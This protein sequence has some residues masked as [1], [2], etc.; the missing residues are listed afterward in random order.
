M[1]K[2]N[3][4]KQNGYYSGTI[5]SLVISIIGLFCF[6]IPLGGAAIGARYIFTCSNQ[7]YRRKR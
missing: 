3:L 1:S 2:V 7:K 6:G 5:L 4:E